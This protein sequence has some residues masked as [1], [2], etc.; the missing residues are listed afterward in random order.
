MFGRNSVGTEARATVTWNI[1]VSL[2]FS[3]VPKARDISH[4]CGVL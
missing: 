1:L 3:L 2:I 4:P